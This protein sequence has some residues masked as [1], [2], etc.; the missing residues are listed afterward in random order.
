VEL[1]RDWEPSSSTLEV[2]SRYWEASKLGEAEG[3]SHSLELLY[4][5][6]EAARVQSTAG[7]T[8]VPA[9]ARRTIPEEW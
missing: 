8:R 7:P 3:L 5:T 2:Q 4:S 6:K 9:M 1:S